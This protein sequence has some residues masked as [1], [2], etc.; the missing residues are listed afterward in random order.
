MASQGRNRLMAEGETRINWESRD[1]VHFIILVWFEIWLLAVTFT[2][3]TQ[4]ET[5][6]LN[7]FVE[8]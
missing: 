3:N 1:V 6:N 8:S 7:P 2:A 5:N 4:S